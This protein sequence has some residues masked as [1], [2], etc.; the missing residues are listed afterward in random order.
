MWVSCCE[1]SALSL[2]MLYHI[3]YHSAA[4]N[5]KM[6]WENVSTPWRCH[7]RQKEYSFSCLYFVPVSENPE[8]GICR[9]LKGSTHDLQSDVH[10]T[11]FVIHTILNF[12]STEIVLTL[13]WS[14][15]LAFIFQS[16]FASLSTI[17][18]TLRLHQVIVL[19]NILLHSN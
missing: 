16:Q 18:C 9:C 19:F 3:R 8:Q 10:Q 17:C 1:C 5:I 2:T 4:A 15:L 6:W 7:K 13:C 11:G 14:S 12:L